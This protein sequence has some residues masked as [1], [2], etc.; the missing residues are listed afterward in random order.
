M[1]VLNLSNGQAD[2]VAFAFTWRD[3]GFC[4]TAKREMIGSQ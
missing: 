4:R 3:S 2:L 1:V